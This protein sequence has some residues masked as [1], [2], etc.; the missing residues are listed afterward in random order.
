[1]KGR[2][3]TGRLCRFVARLTVVGSWSRA[4]DNQ[5]KY[6]SSCSR[7][8]VC[9]RPEMWTKLFGTGYPFPDIP[10]ALGNSYD[11][12]IHLNEVSAAHQR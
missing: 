12:L 1:M 3:P 2:T 7:P 5:P 9:Q 4:E 8:S 6:G 11:V 10:I